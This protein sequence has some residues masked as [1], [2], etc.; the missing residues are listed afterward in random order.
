MIIRRAVGFDAKAPGF[1]GGVNIGTQEQKLPAVLLFLV[2][3]HLPHLFIR[4]LMAGIFH[5]VGGDD[6]QRLLRSILGPGI[7][8]HHAN[9]LDGAAH[10]IQQRRGAAHAVLLFGHRLHLLQRHPIVDDHAVIVKQHGAY[11]RL[12]RLLFLLPQHAV[13]T[14]DGV[15]LQTTHRAAAIQDKNQFSHVKILL[16]RQL[17]VP[18]NCIIT[19]FPRQMV[20]RQATFFFFAIHPRWADQSQTTWR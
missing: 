14:A 9:V 5:A 19:S 12:T 10:G 17:F 2:S 3:D 16:K 20:N 13:E 4:V 1:L 15:L 18:Y 11:Q 6:K 7:L 8:M